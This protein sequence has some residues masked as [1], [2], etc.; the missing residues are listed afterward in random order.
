MNFKPVLTIGVNA[1]YKSSI[2]KLN[3]MILSLFNLEMIANSLLSVTVSRELWKKYSSDQYH[4][5]NIELIELKDDVEVIIVLDG[6]NEP[7]KNNIL[8]LKQRLLKIYKSHLSIVVMNDAQCHGV[9]YAR[10]R[11]LQ[12]AKGKYVKFCD[13][14]DLSVNINELISVINESENADY[15]ECCMTNLTKNKNYPIYTG[16][17]PSNI[18][19]RTQ[20]IRKHKLYFVEDIIG[21]DSVWRFDIYYQLHLSGTAKMLPTSI[22]LIYYKSFKTT[23]DEDVYRYEQMLTNVFE[24]EYSLFGKIPLNPCLFEVLSTLVHGYSYPMKVSDY[25]LNHV[26]MFEFSDILNEIIELHRKIDEQN[27]FYPTS[28]NLNK[29]FKSYYKDDVDND[30]YKRFITRYRVMKDSIT[31][32][33]NEFN[34]IYTKFM[35][36]YTDPYYFRLYIHMMKKRETCFLKPTISNIQYHNVIE[37]FNEPIVKWSLKLERLEYNTINNITDNINFENKKFSFVPFTCLLWC[38]L[39][40]SA[41]F[42]EPTDEPTVEPTVEMVNETV[43]RIT[44]ECIVIDKQVVS[45][46]S[47]YFNIL[48]MLMMLIITIISV[49]WHI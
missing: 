34:I 35:N 45:S 1:C 5:K 32:V 18:I 22:Y 11:V 49:L 3:Q 16:W 47:N 23:S 10:N 17:F 38:W 15:I 2:T 41:M 20:W 9:S 12:H 25:M 43:D 40:S 13:D 24:H 26:D 46:H 42:V 33:E 36:R 31:N 48:S 7:I 14:D 27:E 21:E 6:D 19:V 37:N 29:L 39:N 44:D 8:N 4:E 28:D 30:T